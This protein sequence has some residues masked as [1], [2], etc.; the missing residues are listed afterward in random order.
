MRSALTRAALTGRA[1]QAVA[2][3]L[4]LDVVGV[5]VGRALPRRRGVTEGE[6]R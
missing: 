3:V 1:L 4:V 2:V 5:A 6:K